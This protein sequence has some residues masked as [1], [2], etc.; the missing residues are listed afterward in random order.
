MRKTFFFILIIPAFFGLATPSPAPAASR[1]FLVGVGAYKNLPYF[2]K[3]IGAWMH[4]LKGPINDVTAM[5]ESLVSG[6]GFNPDSIRILTNQEATREAILSNFETWLVQGTRPGDLVLFYFSGH[7]T[8]WPDQNGDEGDGLDEALCPYDVLPSARNY[9][10]SR[11]ITDDELGA[12][13]RKLKGREVVVVID[14]CHSGTMTRSIRG[15]PVSRLEQTPAF[16]TKYLFMDILGEQTRGAGALPSA[17]LPRQDDIPPGQIHISSS[18]EH[19][20]SLEVSLD[21]GFHGALTAGLIEG[22]KKKKEST[23]IEWFNQAKKFV[24]DRLRLEQDPQ[25][26]PAQGHTLQKIVFRPVKFAQTQA[27]AKTPAKSTKVPGVYGSPKTPPQAS[28]ALKT[29]PPDPGPEPQTFSSILLKPLE[30][31]LLVLFEPGSEAS[32]ILIDELKRKLDQISFARTVQL[33]PFDCLIRIGVVVGGYEVR[34]I[35]PAGDTQRFLTSGDSE[36]IMKKIIPHLEYAYL[37]KRLAGVTRATSPFRVDLW[38]KDR[39]RRDYLIGEKAQF[40]FSSEQDCYLLMLNV[41]SR[42]GITILFPNRYYPNNFVPAGKIFEI[43]KNGLGKKFELEFGEPLGEEVIK[44]I[45]TRE[46]LRLG[47]LGLRR[48]D[49][50]AFGPKGLMVVP[51]RHKNSLINKVET[52]PLNNLSWSEDTLVIRSHK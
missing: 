20:L 38:M 22:F 41:D 1:A 16:Q 43:P 25:I 6:V 37:I 39:D 28:P 2:S 5:R 34:V 13:L 44:V 49:Y 52:I 35:T 3:T 24:K 29:E 21:R 23:Y 15:A 50:P 36:E 27:E 45:A 46:P 12:L 19:Q 4:P 10:D 42:G 51:E 8:Q 18:R 32:P 9:K 47:D 17:D 26:D 7:G 48:T 31:Q 33:E 30:T 11:L 14:S 40:F